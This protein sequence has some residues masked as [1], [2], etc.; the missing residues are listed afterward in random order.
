[1]VSFLVLVLETL[2]SHLCV[3]SIPFLISL[4]LVGE[5]VP[6]MAM[7]I[8]LLEGHIQ[9]SEAVIPPLLVTTETQPRLKPTTGKE[10]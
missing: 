5:G 6:K 7:F 2:C 9:Y 1:M 4:S 10:K 3:S 8:D